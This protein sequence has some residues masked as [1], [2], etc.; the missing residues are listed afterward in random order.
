VGLRIHS[1]VFSSQQVQV[2]MEDAQGQVR[3]TRKNRTHT[4]TNEHVKPTGFKWHSTYKDKKANILDS[5]KIGLNY[6]NTPINTLQQH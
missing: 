4:E 2:V 5:M 6:C 3:Y 1:F